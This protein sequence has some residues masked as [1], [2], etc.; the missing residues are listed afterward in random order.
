MKAKKVAGPP[1]CHRYNTIL[2]GPDRNFCPKCSTKY[3]SLCHG[4]YYIDLVAKVEAK[5]C[6]TCADSLDEED[7]QT[8]SASFF[9]S[10]TNRHCHAE[11]RRE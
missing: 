1:S 8:V 9:K 4:V 3:R 7:K 11:L 2:I 6:S 5:N 10:R